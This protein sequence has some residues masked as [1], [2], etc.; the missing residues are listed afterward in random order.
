MIWFLNEHLIN[1][2]I[3]T[4]KEMSTLFAMSQVA[5]FG[6]DL[7]LTP[8]DAASSAELSSGSTAT[9]SVA[10]V[11][12]SMP[13]S[14]SAPQPPRWRINSGDL[15]EMVLRAA[16]GLG[17]DKGIGSDGPPHLEDPI[18]SPPLSRED[19]V[20]QPSPVGF[21][22]SSRGSSPLYRKSGCSAEYQLDPTVDTTAPSSP[23]TPSMHIRSLSAVS[24][25][26]SRSDEASFQHQLSPDASFMAPS[27]AAVPRP[28]SAGG[29]VVATQQGSPGSSSGRFGLKLLVSNSMAGTLI[30]KGGTRICEIKDEV[31]GTMVAAAARACK[32]S[33]QC[34]DFFPTRISHLCTLGYPHRPGFYLLCIL[35]FFGIC[36]AL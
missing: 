15:E 12:W 27:A 31:R 13:E 21:P 24:P 29:G 34:R 8:E 5:L 36:Q 11:G 18:A 20:E 17:L 23:C 28:R 25:T 10:A 32:R 3:T 7:S 9:S 6:R 1:H 19:L 35:F 33:N 2:Q 22:V 16:V 4:R 14:T 30:G 26:S